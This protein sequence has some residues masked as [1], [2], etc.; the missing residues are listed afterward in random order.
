MM[1]AMTRCTATTTPEPVMPTCQVQKWLTGQKALVT[2]AG[3]G[4]GREIALAL[5]QFGADVAVNYVSS[6]SGAESTVREIRD[7]GGRA[8][9]CRA[10]VSDEAAVEAMFAQMLD[11]YGTI[12]ILVNN[13]GLQ[14]DSPFDQMSL[15][16][17][18]RVIGVNLT[19]QFLCSR[20]AIRE[21]KR[22]G[23]RKDVSCAAGKIIC[24]SSVHE[25]IPWAG[26]VNYAASKGGVMLMMKSV[27][28]EVAPLRIRVNS[29]APGAIRTSINMSAWETPQAYSELMKL[30]PYKRI[31]EPSEIG[32]VAAWLASDYAD[33]ITGQSIFVDGGMTLYPGF[34]TGG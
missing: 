18:N 14:Q 3:S 7:A 19:G 34:E 26:H 1:D 6:N 13:A 25:V 16:Q 4:I 15:A 2:G 30:V 8:F 22:R 29:I 28:Q 31:G 9:A 12:D 5:A 32:R 21:F 10:D 23:V 24:V 33:Y 27:A 11:E 17:W 20:A